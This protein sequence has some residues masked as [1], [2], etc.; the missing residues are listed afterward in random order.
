MNSQNIIIID[1]IVKHTTYYDNGEVYSEMFLAVLNPAVADQYPNAYW[2]TKEEQMVEVVKNTVFYKSGY[3]QYKYAF[4]VFNKQITEY[5][6]F[7]EHQ[8]VTV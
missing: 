4:D 8:R 3:V 1:R 5:E 7:Y 2:S 6:I